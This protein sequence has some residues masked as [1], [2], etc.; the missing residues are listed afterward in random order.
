[1]KQLAKTEQNLQKNIFFPWNPH[2]LA[3]I[4]QAKTL[5]G[6]WHIYMKYLGLNVNMYKMMYISSIKGC[7][8]QIDINNIK[9]V[10]V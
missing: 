2:F 4:F 6:F 1:M 5:K 9:G 8:F 3:K 10:P 7:L